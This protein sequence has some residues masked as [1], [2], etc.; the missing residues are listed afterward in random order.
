VVVVPEVPGIGVDL[1][2]ASPAVEDLAG[3][4]AEL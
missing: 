2:T 3:L 1:G 4:H